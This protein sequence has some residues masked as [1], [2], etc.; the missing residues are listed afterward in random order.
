MNQNDLFGSAESIA[1]A[2]ILKERG[3]DA[4][5]AAE[6]EEWIERTYQLVV[7]AWPGPDWRA[8]YLKSWADNMG[9]PQP[10]RPR[11][12]SVIMRRLRDSGLFRNVG[13]VKSEHH[14]HH[15]GAINRWRRI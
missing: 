8:D 2:E 11:G 5:E 4:V 10:D 3:I 7:H 9:W 15:G 14:S 6:S 13:M 1:M 12:W